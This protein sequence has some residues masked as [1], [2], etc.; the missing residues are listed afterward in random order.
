MLLSIFLSIHVVKAMHT[1]TVASATNLS[2]EEVH[3]EKMTDCNICDYH[4]S[5]EAMVASFH[6]HNK[7][8]L[9]CNNFI[10]FY[11][12]HTPSSIGLSYADRG[13]PQ[14]A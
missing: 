10:P 14:T 8:T 2:L 13:P 6:V 9:P 3:V 12:T 4:L 11:K 7:R 5:K 1:H